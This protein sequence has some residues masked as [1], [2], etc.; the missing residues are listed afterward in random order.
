SHEVDQ[1]LPVWKVRDQ[2][3]LAVGGG[4]ELDHAGIA[5]DD[6]RPAVAD[7]V[8]RLDAGN[9]PRAQL[10]DEPSPVERPL[11]GEPQREPAVGGQPVATP[12]PRPQRTRRVAEDLETDTVELPEAAE[13]GG[14]RDL[15]DRQVGVV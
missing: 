10:R 3:E 2:P 11:V 5:V 6:D 1:A 9:S 8:H 14:E 15:G 7:A 4:C 12:P 13:P